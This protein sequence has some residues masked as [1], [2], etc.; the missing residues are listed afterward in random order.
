MQRSLFRDV[1]YYLLM[2]YQFSNGIAD[3]LFRFCIPWLVYD[4]TG[5]PIQMT[6]TFGISM[7]PY[8]LFSFLGGAIIDC[9]NRRRILLITSLLSFFTLLI[10]YS[11]FFQESFTLELGVLYCIAF[12][13]ASYNAFDQPAL[14][15]SIV[16]YFQ[17]NQLISINSSIEVILSISSVAGPLIAGFLIQW[18][19]VKHA[20][21]FIAFFYMLSFLLIKLSRPI[22]ES[23]LNKKF[24]DVGELIYE[25]GQLIKEGFTYL[26]RPSG[27][28]VLL[29]ICMTFLSNVCLGPL[30][31]LLL[32]IGRNTFN[33]NSESFASLISTISLTAVLVLVIVPSKLKK[34][35][36]FLII[37]AA[38]VVQAF[39]YLCI[40]LFQIIPVVFS[41]YFL[42][43]LSASI[44]VIFARTLRQA[45]VP[46][47]LSGRVASITRSIAPAG[48][49]LGAV[50]SSLF[51][52][53]VPVEIFFILNGVL[54]TFVVVVSFQLH[55]KLSRIRMHA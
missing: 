45:T 20:I 6:I 39:A 3:A 55:K 5:S 8:L 32:F 50:F 14:D 40:G 27:S 36:T 24:E 51:L 47:P 30:D 7:L 34:I 49:G 2:G 53:F 9:F 16:E 38:L 43:T 22:Q 19:G 42:I 18:I 44:Y 17:K 23:S 28:P 1:N 46:P 25:Q 48:T 54:M 21:I 13:L 26:L 4:I 52:Q 15:A 29:I 11:L 31:P 41:A 10:F 35:D 12:L 33:M 37:I